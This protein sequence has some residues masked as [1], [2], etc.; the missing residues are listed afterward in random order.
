[1]TVADNAPRSIGD[2]R[3]TGQPTLAPAPRGWTMFLEQ[4]KAEAAP[5]PTS[6]EKDR[7]G[8][9]VNGRFRIK[10]RLGGGTFG[11]VWL[12]RDLITPSD[13]ALKILRTSEPDPGLLRRFGAECEV[14]ANIRNRYLVTVRDFGVT[15]DGHPY[16]ALEYVP[17][18]SLGE[19]LEVGPLPWREVVDVGVQLA[20]ALQALHDGGVIHRDVKPDNAVVGDHGVTLIDLG[21]AKVMEQFDQLRRRSSPIPPRHQTGM[22]RAIGTVG[23]MPIE[24]GLVE[25]NPRFDVYALGATLFCLLTRRLPECGK[26][27]PGVRDL[28]PDCDAPPDLDRVLAGALAVEPDDRTATAAELGRAL[29]AVRDAH[30]ERTPLPLFDGRYERIEV[31]GTTLKTDAYRAYHRGSGLYVALKTLNEA[32]RRNPDE[33]RRLELEARILA[34]L[35]HPILPRYYDY[36]PEQAYIAMELAAGKTASTYC[37]VATRL[38]PVEVANIGLQLARG[39]AALHAIGVIHRDVHARNV[40]IDLRRDPLVKLL[41]LGCVQLSERFYAQVSQRYPTPPE[42][43]LPPLPRHERAEWSAPETRAGKGWTE[44]SDVY[45]LGLLLYRLLTGKV[46]TRSG[47]PIVPPQ[48]HAKNCSDELA[49]AIL[50]ALEADPDDRADMAAMI[51]HLEL[52]LAVELGEHE[53]AGDAESP[54]KSFSNGPTAASKAESSAT[55][56]MAASNVADAEPSAAEPSNSSPTASAAAHTGEPPSAARWWRLGAP[57]AAVVAVVAV[58]GTWFM[59]PPEPVVEDPAP[60]VAAAEAPRSASAPVLDAPRLP[61]VR[62]ALATV[63]GDL[64]DCAG[65]AGGLLIVEFTTAAGRESFA[66]FNVVGDDAPEVGRC[67]RDIADALRFAPTSD[68]TTFTEEYT[69]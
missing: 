58:W 14:L 48:D 66:D 38:R 34:A 11:D 27:P 13:A 7:S 41:D 39:L 62:E 67:V 51:D 9:T 16:M 20:E 19:R 1:M 15:P 23:F 6:C 24:A 25:P 21:H 30:P 46:A 22:G 44:R 53:D 55:P 65:L 37:S 28:A 8:T 47:E 69:R 10:Q 57:V 35:N 60:A 12:A 64:R 49:D 17:G 59:S 43:R 68:A 42:E 40:M 4:G 36:A 54:A 63:A 31:L 33:R 29:A 45:S 52:A 3:T 61:A 2:E 26:P 18:R 56:T 32:G 50:V 5:E